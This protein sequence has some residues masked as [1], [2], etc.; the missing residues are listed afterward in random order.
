MRGRVLCLTSLAAL[1]LAVASPTAQAPV[2]RATNI[3]AILAYPNFYHMRQVLVVGTVAQQQNGE[4]R[5]SDPAGSLRLV[6]DGNAPDG[7]DEVR[8]QFWDLGRMKSDD[9]RFATIDLRRLFNIDPETSW[10]HPGEVMVIM[11]AAIAPAAAPAAVEAAVA[12]TKS[13]AYPATP[14]R[15]VVLEPLRYVGQNVTVTGQFFGRNLAGDLP[16]SPAQSRYD[17][18]MRAADASL[19]ITNVRPR[20]RD[21]QGKPFELGLDTRLD[22]GRW[23]QVSGTVRQGR[24]LVWIDGLENTLAPAQPPAQTIVDDAPVR[25]PAGPPPEVV[26]STPTDDEIDVALTTNIRIQFSRDV[27][28][29]TFRGQIRVTYVTTPGTVPPE[30]PDQPGEFTTQYSAANRVL[31]MKF[32]RPFDRFR[33][34]RV[35]LA[36][37]IL[38]TDKQPLR[39]WTLMF[40]LGGGS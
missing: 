23:L 40:L 2:R 14:L 27:D 33:T 21:A 5:V 8:G 29:T 34:V 7:L 28:P 11:S 19:W 17:F 16:D 1:Y 25:V 20:G 39:P 30:G 32:A 15:S 26:F 4:F 37:G 3:A 22:T 10:P 36:D 38:G 18:V 6:P 24:G 12:T 13:T 31:E 35:D 9:P